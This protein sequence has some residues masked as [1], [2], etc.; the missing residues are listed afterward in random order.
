MNRRFH[1][2]TLLVCASW[3]L[4]GCNVFKHGKQWE[5]VNELVA[6]VRPTEGNTCRG[7]VRFTQVVEGVRIVAH[8]EGLTPNAEHAFHI[9]EFGDATSPDGTSA[10]DHYNPAGHP[11]G[12]PTDA[13]R[14]AGDLGNVVAGADG[15]AHYERV[16]SV[17]TL[18]GIQNPII[19]RAVIVHAGQDKFTQP[20]GEAG[21]RIG[22][23]IIGIA[24]QAKPADAAHH[25]GHK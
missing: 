23:G 11:H 14:H 1:L 2:L 4:T 20:T 24:K 13:K 5:S 21:P 18:V 25:A 22:I 10:G 8:L 16:D 19:G 3:A 12:R 6:V 9:H 15:K 7:T 17:I